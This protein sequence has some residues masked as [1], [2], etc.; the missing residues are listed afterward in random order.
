MQIHFIIFVTQLES[1]SQDDDLYNCDDTVN[2]L[3][4]M[5]KNEDDNTSF[6]EIEKLMNKQIF[7]K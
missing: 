7:R 3:S 4:V 1:V 5:N 6:Y 2:S